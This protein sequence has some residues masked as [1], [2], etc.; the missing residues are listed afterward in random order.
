[1]TDPT[2]YGQAPRG[3]GRRITLTLMSRP[4]HRT[5][6]EHLRALPDEELAALLRARPDLAVPVPIDVSVLASRAQTRMSVARA[7]DHLDLFTLEIL[8]GLRLHEKTSV[9]A[10]GALAGTGA[11][12]AA[13]REAVKTLTTLGIVWPDGD[14]LRVTAAADETCSPYPA[15]LGRP[16]SALV[17]TYSTAQL[18]PILDALSL[19]PTSQPEA[20][21]LLAE[22][23]GERHRVQHLV[24]LAP[25]EAQAVLRKLAEGPPLGAVREARRSVPAAE[26]DT[27]VRWLLA[28]GLLMALD[29]DS[30]ELPREV[31]LVLREANVLGELH[32]SP[33]EIPSVKQPD[34]DR[35][36]SGQATEVLRLVD[37]VLEACAADPP[38]V[39][40]SGGIGVR[41]TRRLAKSAG[42]DEP[43]LPLLLELARSAG[44]LDDT[45]SGD[46]EWL[47]T[48]GYDTWTG[49]TQ[50]VRWAWIARAWLGMTRLPG[51]IGQRDDKDRIIAPLS[52]DAERVSAPELRRMTLAVLAGLPK[53]AAAGPQDVLSLLHWRSPRRGGRRRED[54]VRWALG[55]AAILGV[56]GR[57]A[58]TSY[59][60]A[61]LAGTDPAPVLAAQLPDPL[62]HVL[63]QADLT[64]VAPGPL[65]PELAA[66]LA[67]VADVESAGS[68]TVY[69]V[70]PASVRRALD[71]GRS[72][73]DLHLLFKERSR[74]AVPQA[75]TYLIDDVARR[76]GGLR[77]GS[78]SAYLRSD[79]ETLLTEI[80]A[81]RRCEALRLRRLAPTV[82]IS[83]ATPNRLIDGLRTA[84]Y[85]PVIEDE[86]GT[87]VLSRPDARRAAPRP[88]LTRPGADLP[89]LS[90]DQLT[91]AVRAVRRGDDAARSA[92]RA[93]V[94]TLD[95]PGAT[96]ATAIAVLQQAAR[97]RRQVWLGYVDPH[98]GTLRR[99]LRPLSIGA[100]YLRADDENA[101]ITLTIALHRITSAIL[102][103]EPAAADS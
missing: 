86:F 23:F 80:L 67:L 78:A 31:G 1:M 41:D 20:G 87:L 50:E 84:G 2:G 11:P 77:S 101:D 70:T 5:L 56:T 48:P 19:P 53:N 24:N 74:T 17:T 22:A 27:P 97:E 91:E 8:D 10:L 43:S 29:D 14:H 73:S 51:L 65:Q 68:A 42:V 58:L 85:A 79:D 7:L 63:V 95:A 103:D 75:L 15:G 4:A 9:D 36:G 21:A 64:V 93:P 76:H 88:R 44:L 54:A 52:F 49:E 60:R 16:M 38:G 37:A 82:L 35:A 26:T 98:G 61:L 25:P 89:T 102:T 6:A 62:D 94:T 57:G 45:G 3:R 30:V 46:P 69:R 13:V 32:P 90:D 59:G 66:Q 72:A 92:R 47:P 18:A 12:E 99:L 28:H 71:A 83:T 39:L 55:E 96:A 40:R 100:G 81:D 34:A 33:P